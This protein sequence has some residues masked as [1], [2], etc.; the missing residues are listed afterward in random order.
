MY[1]VHNVKRNFNQHNFCVIKERIKGIFT[2][3][4]GYDNPW[5]ASCAIDDCGGG[6]MVEPKDICAINFIN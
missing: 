5:L 2:Y 4:G 3:F 1:Q 6:I